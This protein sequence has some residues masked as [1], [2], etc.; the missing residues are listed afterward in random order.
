M[1]AGILSRMLQNTDTSY[2][3]IGEEIGVSHKSGFMEINVSQ[4]NDLLSFANL[5]SGTTA[6][7]LPTSNIFCPSGFMQHKFG[8]FIN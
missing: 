6:E 7:Q 8:A 4:I 5:V 1:N 3:E 2:R